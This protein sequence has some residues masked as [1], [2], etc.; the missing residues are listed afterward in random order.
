MAFLEDTVWSCCHRVRHLENGMYMMYLWSTL[1]METKHL[2][3][4]CTVSFFGGQKC[5]KRQDWWP[6]SWISWSFISRFYRKWND[7]EFLQNGSA[8]PILAMILVIWRPKMQ[9]AP[10]LTH[11]VSFLGFQISFIVH[12]KRY[13]VFAE[14]FCKPPF[15]RS[16]WL[17]ECQ[18]GY[19]IKFGTYHEFLGSQSLLCGDDESLMRFCRRILQN[20]GFGGQIR[21]FG[22]Y[23][24]IWRAKVP[25]LVHSMGR[26]ALP[27]TK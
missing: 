26:F 23:K 27:T 5:N 15:W 21:H 6:L 13:W 14:L 10:K 24:W 16:F 11:I 17:F 20:P 1:V 3:K 9:W 8:K 4:P 18:N 25:P 19:I 7:T 2:A 22:G 12:M